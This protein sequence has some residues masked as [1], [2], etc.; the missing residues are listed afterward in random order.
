MTHAAAAPPFRPHTLAAALAAITELQARELGRA[1]STAPQWSATE[2]ALAQAVAAIHGVSPLLTSARQWRGPPAWSRFVA[3]QRTH[4]ARRWQQMQALLRDIDLRACAAGIALVPLKGAA[5]HVAG[6]YAGG[7][8][9]MADLDLLVQ[10]R[11]FAAAAT[12]LSGLGFRHTLSSWKHLVF[13]APSTAAPAALGEH[14]GNALKIELHRHIAERLPHAQL[15]LTALVFPDNPQAGLNAYPSRAA[16]FAHLLLHA[17]GA[18]AL[19]ALRLVQLADLAR[20]SC[21]MDAADW[22]AL[23][24]SSREAL[25]WAYPPLALTARYFPHV[26]RPVLARAQAEC[27]W[28]LRCAYRRRTVATVSLSYPWVSAFPGIEWTRTPREFLQFAAARIAPSAATRRGRREVAQAQP[29]VAGGEWAQLSQTRRVLRYLSARQPRQAALQPVL[30]ALAS[31][32]YPLAQAARTAP[33]R[34]S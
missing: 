1:G 7:E 3:D 12:L 18:L 24:A 14:V 19:R 32:G 8:R 2:W 30:A 5:L 33:V 17:A 25:W 11:H 13:E 20:L 9:P 6:I 26:P 34:V 31:A 10:E 16:L 15:D 28:L 21:H 4:T 23:F 29:R 27:S 22:D